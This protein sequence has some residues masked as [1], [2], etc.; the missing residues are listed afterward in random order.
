VLAERRGF[1]GATAVS[2]Q[3]GRGLF[4]RGKATGAS[5]LWST[6]SIYA[7]LF[8]YLFIYYL[9]KDAVNSSVGITSNIN[10][11]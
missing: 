4:H 8:I 9:F 6:S 5:P 2:C 10:E 7:F 11:Y 1:L 3:M